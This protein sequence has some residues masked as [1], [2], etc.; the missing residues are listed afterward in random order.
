MS[1]STDRVLI[2][3]TLRGD[4]LAFAE[5]VNRYKAAIWRTVRRRLVDHFESED[6]MQEIFMR[7]YTSLHRFDPNRPFDHWILRIAANYCIDV[8]RKRRSRPPLSE[9]EYK[10]TPASCS[11]SPQTERS[12]WN[13]EELNRLAHLLLNEL[14]PKNRNALIMREL[15]GMEYAEV[16]KALH[17]TPLAAR[18]RVSRARKEMNHNLNLYLRTDVSAHTRA[19]LAN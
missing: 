7:A 9:A 18:V 8:I 5:L 14:D 16:A 15:R 3:S 4:E 19:R 2:E 10:E 1:D 12:S 13:P 11:W 17:I 6:A